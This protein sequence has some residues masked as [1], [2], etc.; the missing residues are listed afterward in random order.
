M[1]HEY[2]LTYFEIAVTGNDQNRAKL[3]VG[4]VLLIFVVQ[5]V[6]PNRIKSA[7]VQVDAKTLVLAVALVWIRVP[8]VL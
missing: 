4:F 1:H 7:G 5:V 8:N 3:V 2:A 6:Q